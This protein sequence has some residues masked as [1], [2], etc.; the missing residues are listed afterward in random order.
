MAIV[1]SGGILKTCYID[2]SG[3]GESIG[4]NSPNRITPVFAIVG[5]ILE[6]SELSFISREFIE[7]KREFFPNLSPIK[8]DSHWVLREIKGS[9]LAHTMRTG[10]RKEKRQTIGFIDHTLNL[11]ESHNTKIVGRVWVKKMENFFP[12]VNAYTSS[13]QSI[14]GYFEHFLFTSNKKGI[15]ICDNRSPG[16][17]SPVS[18]S[19][20]TQ[21]FS[22]AGD[23]YEHILEM[24]TFGHSQNHIGLQLADIIVSGLVF[25]IACNT[26]LGSVLPSNV[27]VQG[28]GQA[29]KD[30]FGSRLRALQHLYQTPS[31]TRGG[32]VVSDPNTLKSSKFLFKN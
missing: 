1:V 24:P 15:V 14:Y 31:G 5:V 10:G 4:A 17:N 16:Q 6:S 29:L 18:H 30:R 21:R 20:Y 9:E 3:N 25:P 11:L 2:E 23:P 19:I 8:Q 26:Y 12:E 22:I 13:V 7:L 32:I 27:H 28:A